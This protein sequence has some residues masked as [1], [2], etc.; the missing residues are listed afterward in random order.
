MSMGIKISLLLT[1]AEPVALETC[2][3]I[4]AMRFPQ[5]LLHAVTNPDEAIALFKEHHH[6]IVISDVFFPHNSGVTL[7]R[8]ACAEKPDTLVL[9]LTGD[10]SLNKN[11]LDPYSKELCLHCIINKPLDVSELLLTISSAITT[12]SEAKARSTS[13]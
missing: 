12:V 5:L 2:R 9:V 4:I 1:E 7:A 6:D 10:P 3:K 11:I 8:E 13:L